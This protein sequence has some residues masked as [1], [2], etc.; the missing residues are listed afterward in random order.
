MEFGLVRVGS[1]VECEGR[2]CFAAVLVGPAEKL[3]SLLL[4]IYCGRLDEFL[5]LFLD[6]ALLVILRM[7]YIK[8]QWPVQLGAG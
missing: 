4:S 1:A 5:K 3:R 6:A 2:K 8:Q 7:Y